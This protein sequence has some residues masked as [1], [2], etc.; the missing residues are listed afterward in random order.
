MVKN[1]NC[2]TGRILAG[3]LNCPTRRTFLKKIVPLSS[4]WAKLSYWTVVLQDGVKCIKDFRKKWDHAKIKK[5]WP[6]KDPFPEPEKKRDL[7][8]RHLLDLIHTHLLDLTTTPPCNLWTGTL[9]PLCLNWLIWQLFD[10]KKA[11]VFI[12]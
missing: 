9:V 7:I 10:L 8:D 2:P 5:D 12:F 4:F 11:C 6:Y 1:L 3:N